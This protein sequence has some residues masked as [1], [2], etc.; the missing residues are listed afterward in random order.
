MKA[1]VL[2]AGFGTRLRPLT[3]KVPK[4]LVP[5]CGLPLLRYNLALL[6]GAGVREVVVNTH[7]LGA[8]MEQG[9]IELAR[10]LSLGI[11]VSREE[12]HILGTGGGV[13]RAA[14]ML[15]AGTFFLLNG[16]MLFDVDLAAALAAHRSAQAVA[17]M[18]LAPY[19]KGA[20]YGA[21]EVDAQQ[22]VRRIAGRGAGPAPEQSPLT[23]RHFTGVHVLE[24]E[25]LSRLPP[26]GE[27]D[28]NRTAYVR[29]IHEGARVLGFLQHGYWGDLGAPKS[30]LRA[31]LDVLEGR[32]PLARFRDGADPFA[33]ARE[34]APG[35]F[36]HAGAQVAPGA[37]LAGPL[38]VQAGVSIAAGA[39]VGPF[40]VVGKRVRIDAGAIVQHAAL[41]DGT[42]VGAGE[43]IENAIAAPGVRL[44]CV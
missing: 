10:E 35:V 6:R 7:H 32:V 40:A 31:N 30:L 21:V 5:L 4:P 11:E 29:L 22:H 14:A 38:L 33:G 39:R 16:D 13:R 20:T 25:A 1:M 12:K 23:R 41:W 19:P 26:E 34:E 28:I 2:C 36:V 43:R 15:G 9:A 17:T 3:D 8:A 42:H 44:D 27:S 18:V 37:E 24:P